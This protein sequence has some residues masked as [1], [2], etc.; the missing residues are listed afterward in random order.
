MR[1]DL[2]GDRTCKAELV[3]LSQRLRNIASDIRSLCQAEPDFVLR[4][5]AL[6]K[7]IESVASRLGR[8]K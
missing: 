6:Q 4:L 3:E 8:V 2:L 1:F 5:Q 7:Q